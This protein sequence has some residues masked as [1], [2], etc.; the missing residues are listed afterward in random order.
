MGTLF[1][2]IGSNH[3][4]TEEQVRWHL[5]QRR[6][7]FDFAVILTFIALYAWAATLIVRQVSRRNADHQETAG[8]LVMIVYTSI[9]ASAVGML[10]GEVWSDLMENIRLGSGHLSY[11][12]ERVP[13]ATIAWGY[14]LGASL[15][16][17]S[18]QLSTIRGWSATRGG[19]WTRAR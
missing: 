11:R 17:G 5:T 4:V 14:L 15:Y 13:G 8:W 9:I 2:A 6:T 19:G 3:A 12:L 18:W 1:H 16:S 7:E 10:L